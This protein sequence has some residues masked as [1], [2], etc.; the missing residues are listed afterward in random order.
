MPLNDDVLLTATNEGRELNI[1]FLHNSLKCSF[2]SLEDVSATIV[3]AQAHTSGLTNCLSAVVF[4]CDDITWAKNLY[5]VKHG[6]FVL[7]TSHLCLAFQFAFEK[8]TKCVFLHRS[9]TA[10]IR[11]KVLKCRTQV[12][13]MENSR[14]LQ[15]ARMHNII[16][17]EP[18]NEYSFAI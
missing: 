3:L 7:I 14:K 16:I 9:Q 11:Q 15:Q 2:Q 6:L 10:A 12:K 5:T 8:M 13:S 4:Y 1:L 18:L 17:E